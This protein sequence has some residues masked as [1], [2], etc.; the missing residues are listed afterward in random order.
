MFSFQFGL[1]GHP[2]PS[3]G[4][5]SNKHMGPS[6]LSLSPFCSRLVYFFQTVLEESLQDFIQADSPWIKEKLNLTPASDLQKWLEKKWWRVIDDWFSSLSPD[7]TIIIW[8]SSSRVIFPSLAGV[9]VVPLLI[10]GESTWFSWAEKEEFNWNLLPNKLSSLVL[11][12]QS[13]W[14]RERKRKREGWLFRRSHL[15]IYWKQGKVLW[16]FHP[17]PPSVC[18]TVIRS[19]IWKRRK[20]NKRRRLSLLRPYRGWG[21]EDLKR[22]R[23]RWWWEGRVCSMAE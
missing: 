23:R 12:H 15:F 13:W 14:I 11:K 20:R 9:K 4:E 5:P 10:Q 22:R 18:S 1:D 19:S 3:E 2:C 8:S 16:P 6:S 21:R 17:P 7:L